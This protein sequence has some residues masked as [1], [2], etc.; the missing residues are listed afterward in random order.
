MARCAK[1]VIITCEELVDSSQIRGTSD[2]TAIPHY[3]VDAVAEVRFGSH[4]MFV[5][6]HY[7]CDLPFRREFMRQNRTQEGFE[8]WLDEWVYGT[9]NFERYLEKLGCD[10]L[11]KLTEM[12]HDNYVIKQ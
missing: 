12:E 9:E 10:R 7:W 8:A 5:S 3:C 4:P 11:A 2:M 6:G 1:K